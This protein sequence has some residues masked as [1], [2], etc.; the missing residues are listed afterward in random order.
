[1]RTA[2]K[3]WR[4]ETKSPIKQVLCLF[5]GRVCGETFCAGAKGNAGEFR[6]RWRGGG[7]RRGDGDAGLKGRGNTGGSGDKEGRTGKTC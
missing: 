2:P 4:P 1:M 3:W 6:P 7:G 5:S